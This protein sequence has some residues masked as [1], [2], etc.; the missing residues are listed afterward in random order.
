MSKH[1]SPHARSL[2]RLGVLA[3][4]SASPKLTEDKLCTQT[5]FTVTEE[6]FSV[7]GM[8][9]GL[10]WLPDW[11]SLKKV[12]QQ[13][14]LSQYRQLFFAVVSALQV[15]MASA[16][17][18]GPN[19]MQDCFKEQNSDGVAVIHTEDLSGIIDT[20]PGNMSNALFKMG[21]C[22]QFI[23][24]NCTESFLRNTTLIYNFVYSTPSLVE[25]CVNYTLQTVGHFS[26]SDTFDISRILCIINKGQSLLANITAQ[27]QQQL[28]KD[29]GT[30]PAGAIVGSLAAVGL[31]AA[32][33]GYLYH[34]H[35]KHGHLPCRGTLTQSSSNY[36][37]I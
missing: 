23:L 20:F 8:R 6:G 7:N 21:E 31:V 34:Y 17:H 26:I 9:I 32:A 24:T 11:Q 37:K 19:G 25:R 28:P 35:K 1:R 36:N 16:H 10:S 27:A 33:A 15:Q 5:Q 13:V 29:E 2:K 12:H 22:G 3:K 4:K 30:S 14:D 18:Y